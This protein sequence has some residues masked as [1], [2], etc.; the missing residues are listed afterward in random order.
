MIPALTLG[1]LPR[2][3]AEAKTEEQN[4]SSEQSTLELTFAPAHTVAGAGEQ[5]AVVRGIDP[6]GRAAKSGL[7]TGDIIID[8]GRGSVNTPADVRKMVDEAR[9]ES[10]RAVLMRIKRGDTM[11]FVA[12]PIG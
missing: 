10:K 9:A 7:Q 3:S 8:V 11:S 5:G 2:T 6:N 4:P 12:V 1:E